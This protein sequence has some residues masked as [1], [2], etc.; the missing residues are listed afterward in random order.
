[1]ATKIKSTTAGDFLEVTPDGII[2]LT[3][4]RQVLVDIAKAENL[5]R[6]V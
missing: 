3:T 5:P 2:N 6:Y 1:M 4:S